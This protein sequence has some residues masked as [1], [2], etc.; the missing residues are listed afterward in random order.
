MH[1]Q[2]QLHVL[3]LILRDENIAVPSELN[4]G[5][6]IDDDHSDQNATEVVNKTLQ[7]LI[8]RQKLI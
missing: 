1:R 2:K 4:H 6:N 8:M 7:G 3:R 5:A